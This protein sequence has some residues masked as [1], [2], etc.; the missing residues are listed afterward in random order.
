MLDSGEYSEAADADDSPSETSESIGEIERDTSAEFEIETAFQVQDAADSLRQLPGLDQTSWQ[1]LDGQ[2]RLETLQGVENELA[3]VQGRPEV[4]V[5]AE[6]MP[7]GTFGGFDGSRI[8][9]NDADLQSEMPVDEHID[10]IVH[11]GRH[12]YQQYAV[13]NP[14]LVSDR[15]T[16]EAWADN[17]QNYLPAEIYG[18]EIY[19]SQPVEADAFAYANGVVDAL[20]EGEAGG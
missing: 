18:Q 10:T 1:T 16:V 5:T 9:V 11:E 3:G 17:S 7:P 14:G 2:Q 12:A 20:H 13:E 15:Q 8:V 19:A 6:E 4:P